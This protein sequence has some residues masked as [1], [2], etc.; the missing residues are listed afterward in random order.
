M[1]SIDSVLNPWLLNSKEYAAGKTFEYVMEK[2][3]F[4][5]EEI[6][7]LAGNE[8]TLG[9]SQQAIE[10][11]IQAI[12]GS[13]F[14]DE[15][16]SESLVVEIEHKLA[17]EGLDLN[18]AGVVVGNGMDSIIEHL[19][20]LFTDSQSSII[21]LPPTFTYYQFTA[22]RHGVELINIPRQEIKQGKFLGYAIDIEQIKKSIKA[23]TKMV[24]L[25][26]P[27]N[28]DGSVI[29]KSQIEDLAKYLLTKNILLFVDHAYVDF[30]D[31]S[32]YDATLLVNQY[33]NLIVG[34]TFSKAYALAGFRVGYAVVPQALKQKYFTHMTPFLCSRP[35]IAA[36]K[37]ALQDQTH[38]QKI[39]K[40]TQAERETLGLE[41]LGLDFEV[42]DTQSN[43]YL[44]RPN[45]ALLA[46]LQESYSQDSLG[47]KSIADY[48]LEKLMSKGIIVRAM[49]SVSP[50]TLRITIGTPEENKRLIKSLK[51]IL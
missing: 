33:P 51:E 42:F 38:L 41:L 19:F 46:R 32:K 44:I 4:K 48:V 47:T 40:S 25:C 15:P 39:I 5:R 16:N 37:A 26:S 22:K 43:F 23:N 2:Y 11:A 50:E 10:A 17:K 36:A 20:M 7:R 35:S 8:T 27:N 13:N 28:P 30:C 24:F 29:E 14:Y 1:F 12:N 49:N 9:I 6:L 21:D 18:K 31:R 3:G 34:F 45:P